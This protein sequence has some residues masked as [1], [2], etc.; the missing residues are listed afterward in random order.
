MAHAAI[1]GSDGGRAVSR[2]GVLLGGLAV[3]AA[4]GGGV[5]FGALQR[6]NSDEPGAPPP[7]LMAALAAERQ[8]IASI[9]ATT[10]GDA[11]VRAALT[12]AK[13]APPGHRT[14]CL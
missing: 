9:D 7:E 1:T 6:L 11:S 13:P 12:Y 2:R 8:L 10:G 3:A 4:G 14:E 5:T